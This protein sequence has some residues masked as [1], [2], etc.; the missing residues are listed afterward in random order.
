M[1]RVVVLEGEEITEVCS[2][3]TNGIKEHSVQ[4]ARLFKIVLFTS[5]LCCVARVE[6]ARLCSWNA[7]Y[8]KYQCY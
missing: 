3:S 8:E 5:I 7:F 1:H 4:S 6:L 2:G